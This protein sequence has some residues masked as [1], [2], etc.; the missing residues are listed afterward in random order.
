ME[1][2]KRQKQQNYNGRMKKTT[3]WFPGHF[4]QCIYKVCHAPLFQKSVEPTTSCVA[5]KVSSLKYHHSISNQVK[6]RRIAGNLA[7][8]TDK[9]CPWQ[10]LLRQFFLPK[11]INR[12]SNIFWLSRLRL[13]IPQQYLVATCTWFRTFLRP[14]WR[15]YVF[16]RTPRNE[17]RSSMWRQSNT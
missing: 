14:W 5:W 15:Q 9:L 6:G 11:C 8:N 7:R 4:L 10:K 1:L 16:R 2:S 13:S 12:A 3:S 17:Q